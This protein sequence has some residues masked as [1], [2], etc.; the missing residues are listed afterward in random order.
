MRRLLPLLSVVALGCNPGAFEDFVGAAAERVDDAGQRNEDA[1]VS[2]AADAAGVDARV[3]DAS[4]V[5][6][7]RT[8]DAIVEPTDAEVVDS[9][10]AQPELDSCGQRRPR[11]Q[12]AI[13]DNGVT[14]AGSI[15]ENPQVQPRWPTSVVA[16]DQDT[17]WLFGPAYRPSSVL[18]Q[19]TD[20]ITRAPRAMPYALAEAADAAPA[21]TPFLPALDVDRAQ[22]ASGEQLVHNTGN[23]MLTSERDG[24]LFYAVGA[25]GAGLKVRSLGTRLADVHFEGGKATA[26]PR[27]ALVLGPT[28]TPFR[29]GVLAEGYVYLYGCVQNVFTAYDCVVARAPVAEAGV[30]ASYQFR[31][32]GGWSSD[33]TS[34]TYVISGARDELSIS[35]NPFLQRYLAV[36]LYGIAAQLNLSTSRQPD[37]PWEPLGVIE[38]PPPEGG[39]ITHYGG[40]EQPALAE[41]CGRKLVLSY[42]F[43][44]ADNA[45]ELRRIEVLLREEPAP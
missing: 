4:T 10:P 11:T 16:I 23:V 13:A 5:Q 29:H 2:P 45:S 37:G 31:T 33:Y 6:D 26:T 15:A 41:L 18:L 25:L 43:G 1:Q 24:L 19:T 7:A 20:S 22:L 42:V 27:S 38:L 30:G 36:H 9:G 8:Q 14:F 21:P 28:T 35:F 34:A 39:Q 32:T 40:M 44:R 17:W 12:L 3:V